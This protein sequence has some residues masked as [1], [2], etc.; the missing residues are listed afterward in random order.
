ME[1]VGFI[2]LG[3]MG[4]GMAANIQKAGYPLVVYDVRGETTSLFVDGG[5]QLAS[6]ATE[7]AC[8]SDV[9]FTS[10]PGP[11]E[12]EE[13]ILGSDGLLDNAL[14]GDV[15]VDLS[16][17]LPETSDKLASAC[18]AKGVSFA[19]APIGRLAQHAWEGTSMFMV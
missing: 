6:S 12:V 14:A 7:V 8:L 11:R 18:A 5:A 10:L 17:V 9:I 19:D 1:T 3:T 2:G 16:T 13:V 4:T 15:I